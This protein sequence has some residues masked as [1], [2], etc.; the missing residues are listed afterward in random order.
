MRAA[1]VVEDRKM[2]VKDM[3]LPEPKE[4]EV[5]IKVAMAGLCGSDFSLFHGKCKVPFPVIGGHEAVGSIDKTG[6]GVDSGL[7][8]QRVT[9]HPNYYCSECGPCKKGLT[10]ICEKKVRLGIDTDGVFAEYV[11][12]N[13]KQAI[14]VP[15]GLKDEVAVFAEPLSVITHAM[16]VAAPAPDDKVLIFGAGAMGLITLQM[17]KLHGGKVT[18]CDIQEERIQKA[19]ELGAV[20][21]IGPDDTPL[22]YYNRFDIVYETSGAPIALAEAMNFV[23]PG[24]TIVV[25]GL[26]GQ[27][28]PISA[29]QIVRKE[30]KI[31]GSMIY[32]NEF[33]RSMEIL[34]EGKIDT[35]ALT[36]GILSLDEIAGALVDFRSPVRVKTLVKI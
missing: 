13:A 20:D 12:V 27:S 16:N 28:S 34:L 26:P 19:K 9:I 36:S 33:A 35:Q 21:T 8:G 25:L 29:E 30:I 4:D 14:P 24:G 32:T 23:A 17:A 5:R 11:V 2:I 7:V 1:V 31:L 22:D 18:S 6:P 10:N 15:A 3:P